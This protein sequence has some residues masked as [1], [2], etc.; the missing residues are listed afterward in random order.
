[1]RANGLI[2]VVSRNVGACALVALLASGGCRSGDEPTVEPVEARSAALT[3]SPL[4]RAGWIATASPTSSSEPPSRAIDGNPATR[5]STGAPQ[6]NGQWFQVDMR[7]AQ[8]FTQLVLDTTASSGDYPRGYQVL[9]SSDGAAWSAPVATGTGTGAIVTINFPY[10]SARYVRVVQ[11]SSNNG[12]WWSIHELN[13]F[14]VGPVLMSRTGWKAS[15]SATCLPD[16]AAN[17]LDGNVNTRWSTGL[18]QASG[19]WF[20]IDML[21]PRSFSQLTLD[22]GSSSSDY[23]RGYK[24]QT[25]NDGTSWSSPVATGS[26][27]A[28]QLTIT[29]PAQTAR[30][31]RIT[32]TTGSSNWWSIHEI[33]VWEPPILGYLQCGTQLT[34]GGYG[35]WFG[36]ESRAGADIVVPLGV[37]NQ[38]LPAP[39]TGAPVTTFQPGKH[40]SAFYVTSTS[41]AQLVWTLRNVQVVVGPGSPRT[42]VDSD[43]PSTRPLPAGVTDPVSSSD[44]SAAALA[45]YALAEAPPP[46]PPPPS[47]VLEQA[48]SALTIGPTSP[49]PFAFRI[50]RVKVGSDGFLES[51]DMNA[52]VKIDGQDVGQNQ[53]GPCDPHPNVGCIFQ[54]DYAVDTSFTKIVPH[55]QPTVAVH[56]DLVELDVVTG[57]DSLGTIDLTVDPRTGTWTG[58]T[59][60]PTNCLD[61]AD[62]WRVCWDIQ[63]LDPP[64]A[65]TNLVSVCPT[66]RAHFID[67]GY[68]ED[69]GNTEA[70]MQFPA[71]FMKAQVIA[72]GG[73]SF[74]ADAATGGFGQLDGNGCTP[75]IFPASAFSAPAIGGTLVVQATLESH[76][77]NGDVTWNVVSTTPET[78]NVRPAAGG[79][80]TFTSMTRQ[81]ATT[82][83][84]AV[85]SLQAGDFKGWPRVNGWVIPPSQ[86]VVDDK[87]VGVSGTE[88]VDV[89]R[90]SVVVGQM[91]STPDNGMS[92][93]T[94][95]AHANDG[96]PTTNVGILGDSCKSGDDLFIG[97]GKGCPANR[98]SQSAWKYIIAHEAG[99]LIQDRAMG[100]PF[101]GGN[102]A[103]PYLFG[104]AND[105]AGAGDFCSCNHVVSANGEHCLQSLERNGTSQVEGFA[106][107]Y[108]SKTWNLPDEGE[109]RFNYYKEFL[110]TQC[111]PGTKE[112]DNFN[113]HVRSRPPVPVSCKQ[114]AKWRNRHC[115]TVNSDFA[116]EFDWLGFFFNLNTSGPNKVSM[117]RLYDV[118]HSACGGACL[119]F[120]GWEGCT[121]ASCT[122]PEAS[123]RQAA[124][125]TLG[126][127]SPAFANLSELGD[128]FGVSRDV[129]P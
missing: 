63:T 52:I 102:V 92:P 13:V 34:A 46:P 89:A 60:S 5:W 24:V 73:V 97:P 124:E 111:K 123:F 94:Y 80:C 79:G 70:P 44:P 42:C 47:T 81:E 59:T 49:P 110:D 119:S 6:A 108:A 53:L 28:P 7:T 22:S 116:T 64:P 30:F 71:R 72:P 125:T 1:M 3:A 98:P 11:T 19:Q 74:P 85:G 56:V 23:P 33:N 112:C 45:A 50:T 96:C 65:P 118:Y 101:G 29:F 61:L 87:T 58:T 128:R 86:I 4:P 32:L 31:V 40:A 103:D 93:G 90:V 104:D 25:S 38:V 12:H 62:G 113:G 83:F 15:A 114:P 75:A 18:T 106:Q 54:N 66:V 109:C 8:S 84:S 129:S 55:D 115:P 21:Q 105:P 107:F 122:V 91:M 36:Y 39:A 88:D 69:F 14:G 117:Q 100:T 127:T 82:R 99:H 2:R 126:A 27:A 120:V 20:Q 35:A 37:D 26:G 57:N 16:V 48:Q 121:T 68:G 9:V 95:T 17:A 10:Q 51:P 41:A 67:A 43:Y 77:V 76:L 78:R